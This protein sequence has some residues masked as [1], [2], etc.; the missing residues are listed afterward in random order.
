M[1]KKELAMRLQVIDQELKGLEDEKK[2]LREEL[3]GKMKP[4]EIIVF[5]TPEGP[6]KAKACET[7]VKIL[8]KNSE[9]L[10]EIGLQGYLA[11][12]TVQC[13][14]LETY[15]KGAGDPGTMLARCIMAVETKTVLKI[16]KGAA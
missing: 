11:S 15:L 16:L 4:G 9:I 6:Y 5:E 14:K 13:G 8:R 12:S 10:D 2:E 1:K 3:L 7:N